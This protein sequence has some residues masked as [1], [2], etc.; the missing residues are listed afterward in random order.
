MRPL[1][2]LSLKT[3]NTAKFSMTRKAT[4]ITTFIKESVKQ[5]SIKHIRS[6]HYATHLRPLYSSTEEIPKISEVTEIFS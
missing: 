4:H 2:F 3:I 5:N 6:K 1:L